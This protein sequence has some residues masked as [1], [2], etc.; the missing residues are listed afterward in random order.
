MSA[1]GDDD[2]AEFEPIGIIYSPFRQAGTPLLDI[3]PYAPRFGHFQ[4]SRSG[5]LD[6]VGRDRS[7]ADR[8][9]A[10]PA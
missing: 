6:Q 9:F 4:V 2:S 5:W 8:R 1:A 7:V 3:K 10:P